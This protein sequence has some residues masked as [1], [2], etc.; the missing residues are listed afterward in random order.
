MT[1]L[2]KQTDAVMKAI[3]DLSARAKDAGDGD[4]MYAANRAWTQLYNH[5][6]RASEFATYKERVESLSIIPQVRALHRQ[7]SWLYPPQSV[8]KR[9]GG[10]SECLARF[11]ARRLRVLVE[12]NYQKRGREKR[13]DSFTPR[14][15]QPAWR[16][17][18]HLC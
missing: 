2:R 9:D 1:D 11:L 14:S 5:Q 4:L 18:R 13:S 16:R 6:T 10:N 8:E 7:A 12:F 15:G 3:S 17:A